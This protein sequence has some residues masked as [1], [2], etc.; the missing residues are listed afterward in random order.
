M[1]TSKS[2][3]A[4]VVLVIITFLVMGAAD[5][6]H[7]PDDSIAQLKARISSL[8]QRVEGLEKKLQTSTTNRSSLTRRPSSPSRE[9]SSV[10]RRPSSPPRGQSLP[11]GWRRKEFNGIPYYL[12]PLGQKQ[13]R[14][15]RRSSSK[16]HR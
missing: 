10:T 1:K 2:I 3:A 15:S 13:T 4:V 12:V 11:R 9:R 16:A 8:E 5:L 7:C 6:N 14:P